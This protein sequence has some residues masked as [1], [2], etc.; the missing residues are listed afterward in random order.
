VLE[1]IES[2]S[3]LSDSLSWSPFKFDEDDEEQGPVEV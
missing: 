3:Y 1:N 2:L